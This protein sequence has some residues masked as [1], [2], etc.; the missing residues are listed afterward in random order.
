MDV[1]NLAKSALV[2]FHASRERP[3]RLATIFG[4]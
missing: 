4:A 2:W 3:S 1:A